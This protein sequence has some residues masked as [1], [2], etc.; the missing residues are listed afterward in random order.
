MCD[1]L[2]NT[3]ETEKDERQK[4]KTKKTQQQNRHELNA[5]VTLRQEKSKIASENECVYKQL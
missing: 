5:F 3:I 2:M 4:Q 1:C